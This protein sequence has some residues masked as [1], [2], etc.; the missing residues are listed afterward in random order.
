MVAMVSWRLKACA[1]ERVGG[2][3]AE[4]LGDGIAKSYG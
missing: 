1:S 3:D 2:N 4:G